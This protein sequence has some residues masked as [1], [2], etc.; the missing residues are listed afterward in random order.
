M[1][2]E[3]LCN[4]TVHAVEGDHGITL[5]EHLVAEALNGVA[6]SGETLEAGRRAEAMAN[7]AIDAMMIRRYGGK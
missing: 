5:Y 4:A 1:N 6:A 2:R 7:D 3:Q